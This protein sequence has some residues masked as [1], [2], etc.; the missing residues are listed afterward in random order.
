MNVYTCMFRLHIDVLKFVLM[1]YGCFVLDEGHDRESSETLNGDMTLHNTLNIR[2][3]LPC[4]RRHP[5][6]I[7]NTC[8]LYS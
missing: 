8:K 6:I 2:I 4:L 3:C 7:S 1:H 5:N